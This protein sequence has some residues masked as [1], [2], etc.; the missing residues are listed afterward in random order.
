MPILRVTAAFF[1]CGA[2]MI[3]G[4]SVS[5]A[6]NDKPP[7]IPNLGGLLSDN[8]SVWL[9]ELSKL[10]TDR[11]LAQ[12]KL[13]QALLSN[14]EDKNRWRVYHHLTE[15]GIADDLPF[16][17]DKY[18]EVGDKREKKAL[19]GSALALYTP[20][21]EVGDLVYSIAGFSFSQKGSSKSVRSREKGKYTVSSDQ[22]DALHRAGLPLEIIDRV[23]TLRGKRYDDRESLEDD[24]HKSL[25]NDR[26]ELYNS[27]LLEQF[28]PMPARAELEGFLRVEIRNPRRTPL[29]L[30]IT[31]HAWNGYFSPEP[32]PAYLYM[33]GEQT[34]R[35]SVPVRT[36]WQTE[37]PLRVDLRMRE[38]KGK[39]VPVFQKLLIEG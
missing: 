12:A 18:N 38:A 13:H 17:I 20:A 26:W 11:K 5:I 15:F 16:L 8:E 4:A 14:L 30:E 27:K 7:P 23:S 25:G 28:Q 9:E 39:P 21:R 35:I 2:I 3:L 34:N 6:K 33:E 1:L 19:L 37:G 24:L 10:R 31:F 22:I 32:T 29:L 36:I